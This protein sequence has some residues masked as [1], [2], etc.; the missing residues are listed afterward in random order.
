MRLYD[1]VFG[2]LIGDV[3]VVC[4]DICCCNAC[5]NGGDLLVQ[6]KFM[7]VCR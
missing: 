7:V 4:C 3:V 1:L 5:I 6:R 2:D